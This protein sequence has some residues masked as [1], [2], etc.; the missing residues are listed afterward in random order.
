MFRVWIDEIPLE[1][2]LSLFDGVAQLVGPN[3]PIEELATCDAALDPGARWNAERMDRAPRLRVISRIGVGYDNIDVEAATQRGIAVCYTPHGPTLS[4]AEH[5]VA[6]IFASAKTIAFADRDMRAG[7]WHSDFYRLKGMELRGRILGLVGLG[8]IATLVAGVMQ[9]V[10]MQV[11]AIDPY[12]SHQRAEELKVEKMDSLESLLARADVVSLHA[13]STPETRHLIN[14]STLS[15]MKPGAILINTARGA[16]VDEL[17]LANALKSGHLAAAGLDVFEHEPVKPDNPLLQ[18]ENVV[19]TDHI[20]SHTWSGHHRLY[21]MAV[22][23]LLQALRGEKPDCMLN[24]VADTP[25][26]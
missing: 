13:P 7:R 6:L 19:L 9:A 18:L 22:I 15:V 23:H 2:V 3:A 21:E 14:A 4:T 1:S 12:L 8:R 20:A 5:A 16:L 25:K 24:D 26:R 11:I 17:A 10:G